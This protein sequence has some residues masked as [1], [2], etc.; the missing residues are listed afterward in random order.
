MTAVR[1]EDEMKLGGV[2]EKIPAIVSSVAALS[3]GISVS[4]ELG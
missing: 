2:V 4:A 1:G 3:V